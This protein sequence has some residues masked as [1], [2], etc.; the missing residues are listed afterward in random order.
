MFA[1]INSYRSK[2]PTTTGYPRY[3]LGI[4]DYFSY[5]VQSPVDIRIY[6]FAD[7]RLEQAPLYAS[8]LVFLVL[9]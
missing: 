7:R 4:T 9:A 3:N 1:H 5:Y 6:G 2:E 8:P